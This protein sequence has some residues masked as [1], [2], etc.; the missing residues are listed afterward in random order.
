MR[1][2]PPTIEQIGLENYMTDNDYDYAEFRRRYGQLNEPKTVIARAF[3]VDRKTIDRW[4]AV[5]EKER[6]NV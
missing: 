3:G 4:I 2:K 1:H 5:F 6:G